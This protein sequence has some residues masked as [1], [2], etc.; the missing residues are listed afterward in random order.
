MVTGNE[1]VK[2]Y[3]LQDGT[4]ISSRELAKAEP[5]VQLDAMRKW[6]YR[7]YEDPVHSCPHDSSEGGYQ[8]VY[9]GPYDAQEEL[10]QEFGGTVDDDVVEKLA[11]ELDDECANWSGNSDN[12]SPDLDEYLFLSSA[13]SAGHEEAFRQSS[14]NI[15]R[16]LEAKVQP[17]ERQ[18]MLRLLY[19]NVITALETYLSDKFISAITT[20][21]KLLRRFVETTPEFKN[22]KLSLSDVFNAHETIKDDVKTHLLEVVWHR[23]DKVEPMFRYTLDINFPSDMKEF[24][25][26]IFVRHDCVHRNGKTKNGKEHVFNE[27]E[28]KELL[29]AADKLIR[30]IEAGGKELPSM[31]SSA[32][33][34]ILNDDPPDVQF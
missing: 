8:F 34:P 23:L 18:V 16:L 5:E 26:A 13:E 6:F 27:D 1:K 33:H 14:V 7:N 12:L 2:G 3:T 20:D 17:A 24:H 19:T 11:S 30:W 21:E 4:H 22:R 32:E 25:K 9:G 10:D 31:E 15:E 29:S 28:I